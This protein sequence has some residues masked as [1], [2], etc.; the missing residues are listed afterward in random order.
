MPVLHLHYSRGGGKLLSRNHLAPLDFL[1]DCLLTLTHFL[2][3][4]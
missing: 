3:A 4:V 2:T 1:I